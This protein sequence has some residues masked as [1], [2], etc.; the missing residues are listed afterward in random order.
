MT[1][2]RRGELLDVAAF[3]ILVGIAMVAAGLRERHLVLVLL[4]WLPIRWGLVRVAAAAKSDA[5][6]PLPRREPP[7]GYEPDGPVR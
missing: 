7:F 6:A 3:W 5:P 1:D 2:K 4:A